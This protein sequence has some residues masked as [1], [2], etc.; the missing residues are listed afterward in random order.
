MG[1]SHGVLSRN[2]ARSLLDAFK[3]SYCLVFLTCL[4]VAVLIT[5]P[6]SANLADSRYLPPH[7]TCCIVHLS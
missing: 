2:L 6:S 5:R 4:F 7:C 3:N 1:R